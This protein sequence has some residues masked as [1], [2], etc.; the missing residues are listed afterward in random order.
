MSVKVK[1]KDLAVG[2]EFNAG[3]ATLRILDHFTDGTTLV[4]TSVSIGD[5]PFG[6]FPFSYE[7]YREFNL[8]DWRTSTVR[9]DLNE[10]FMSALQAAGRVDTNKIV[11]T[12]WDLSDHQGGAGYGTSHDKIGLLTE[13]MFRKYAEQGLLKLNDWWWLITPTAGQSYYV[14]SVGASGKVLNSYA[15]VGIRGVRPAFRLESETEVG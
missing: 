12:E 6:V 11:V 14:R 3:P 13:A 9:R 2:T 10:N 8:N 7:L 1:I 15:Y 4:I 5:R